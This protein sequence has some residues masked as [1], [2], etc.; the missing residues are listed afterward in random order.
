MRRLLSF[1]SAFLFASA[2]S[3]MGPGCGGLPARPATELLTELRV[4]MDRPVS[5][6]EQSAAQSRR[7]EEA[8]D[9][10]AL[11]DMT[12]LEVQNSIGLGED[13]AGHPRCAEA[14]FQGSDWFYEVGE[15]AEGYAGPLPILI[16]GFDRTG[17]VTR[18]W[19]LRTH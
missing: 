19:N 15:A 14:G 12:R 6:G 17:A 18:T 13:C 8:L 9:A 10:H 16:V 1:A 2:A 4:S 3:L 7:V 11:D 5:S